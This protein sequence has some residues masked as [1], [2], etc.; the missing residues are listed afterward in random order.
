MEQVLH[1]CACTIETVRREI[2]NSKKS[3]KALS[4][5][6]GFSYRMVSKG[7]IGT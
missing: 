7:S 1:G 6:R 2:R 4:E 3:V 5:G